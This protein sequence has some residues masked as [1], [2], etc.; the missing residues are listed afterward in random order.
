L[1]AIIKRYNKTLFT[2]NKLLAF[3]VFL[4]SLKVQFKAIKVKDFIV[5]TS[6]KSFIKDISN[7]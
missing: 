2:R 7:K 4:L 1:Q 5:N 6:L 3:K